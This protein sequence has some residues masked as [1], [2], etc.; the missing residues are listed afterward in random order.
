[1]YPPNARA[2]LHRALAAVD[3][4]RRKRMEREQISRGGVQQASVWASWGTSTLKTRT[5]LFM[6]TF[7]FLLL[8]LCYEI[9]GTL[10]PGTEYC[11]NRSRDTQ[12]VDLHSPHD[13]MTTP[14]C[15]CLY[16]LSPIGFSTLNA[17]RMSAFFCLLRH[18]RIPRGSLT[19]GPSLARSRAIQIRSM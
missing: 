13:H 7:C 17:R 9:P 10:L 3:E 18:R 15:T 11:I 4:T 6:R 5:L 8:I 14:V 2:L 19:Y 16:I 1:M 12:G